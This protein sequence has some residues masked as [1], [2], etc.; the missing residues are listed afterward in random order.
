MSTLSQARSQVGPGGKPFKK[1]FISQKTLPKQ[2]K[3]RFDVL[4]TIMAV[5]A[6]TLAKLTAKFACFSTNIYKIGC[7]L[8]LQLI[9]K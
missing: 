3:N 2:I 7:E 4:C 8:R 9:D 5:I 1:F 6:V